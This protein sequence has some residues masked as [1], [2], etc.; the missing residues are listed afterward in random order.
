MSQSSVSTANVFMGGSDYDTLYLG[1]VSEAPKL[2]ALQLW[3]AVPATLIPV[4]WLSDDG[5]VRGMDDSKKT[6]Q[7]HQGHAVVVTYMDSSETSLQATILEHKLSVVKALLSAEG[8]TEKKQDADG[9]EGSKD[10][11]ELTAKHSRR[12]EHLCG[13]WDTFDTAHDNVKY[14]YVFPALDLSERDETSDKPGEFSALPMT[15]DVLA[16]YRVL[17]NVPGMLPA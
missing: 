13:V 1:P 12:I 2:A 5:V 4:G 14:R 3:T 6:V 11:V 7:G 16:D 10:F 9:P 8:G 15:L 17:T